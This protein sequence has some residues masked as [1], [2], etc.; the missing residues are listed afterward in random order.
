MKYYLWKVGGRIRLLKYY[1]HAVMIIGTEEI[2]DYI[3][4]G[5]DRNDLSIKDA[6]GYKR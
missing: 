3:F 5:R 4:G 1:L 2:K 6:R